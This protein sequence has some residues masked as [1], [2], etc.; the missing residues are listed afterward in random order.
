MSDSSVSFKP[1]EDGT[2]SE[3]DAE[4]FENPSFQGALG[5]YSPPLKT[6]H[7]STVHPRC[8]AYSARKD[9]PQL[10]YSAV[11][12]AATLPIDEY[13]TLFEESLKDTISGSASEN[14]SKLSSQYGA[15]RWTDKEETAFFAALAKNGRDGVPAIAASIGTKSQMEVRHYLDLLQ[16]NLE[17][18]HLTDRN[19]KPVELSDIPAAYEISDECCLALE[20]ISN[21]LCLREEQTSNMVGR[22]KYGDSWLVNRETAALVERA[23]DLEEPSTSDRLSS[24]E[25]LPEV[26]FKPGSPSRC[27]LQSK[28]ETMASKHQSL[29]ATAKLLNICNWVQLSERVFMNSG[30]KR[31]ENNWQH[32]CFQDETPAL[33]CDA[34]SDFYALAISITRRLIQA[35]IFFALSRIRAVQR[36]HVIPESLVKVEDVFAAL[37]VLKME[38]SSKEF[39]IGAPRRNA[40]DIK[41]KKMNKT[42]PLDYDTV[43]A[44]LSK[45]IDITFKDIQT[46]GSSSIPSTSVSPV[47]L[48]DSEHDTD[49]DELSTNESVEESLL[50]P[51]EMCANALDIQANRTE[52]SNLWQRIHKTIPGRFDIDVK[53]EFE[54]SNAQRMPSKKR[55]GRDELADWR[56]HTLYQAEWET[57]GLD[58]VTLNQRMRENS[59]AKRPKPNPA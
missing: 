29:F 34:M 59:D 51:E 58:T 39:W 56:D 10:R 13:S 32:I 38:Q 42:A 49:P 25:P 8:N 15:V 50:E 17:L 7:Y 20:H 23:L 53:A 46:I 4:S 35:S 30:E 54:D 52:E 14:T 2:E 55:K 19:V 26:G 24:P 45:K 43:E 1:D 3:F 36:T 12:A 44:L 28:H 40:L 47:M 31:V 16:H 9:R 5:N 27:E 18:H 57:F 21:A 33:T 48:E 22:K 11:R 41:R 37:T 6:F